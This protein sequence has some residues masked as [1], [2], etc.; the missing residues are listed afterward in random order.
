MTK[1]SDNDDDDGDGDDD[2]VDNVDDGTNST[3]LKLEQQQKIETSKRNRI[4][5]LVYTYI[6][7]WF[8]Y[9]RDLLCLDTSLTVAMLFIMKKER[10]ERKKEPFQKPF[11]K[12]KSEEKIW[13]LRVLIKHHMNDVGQQ[14]PN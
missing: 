5:I 9:A 6:Y 11:D 3:Y 2:H 8:D 12:Y 13:P 1:I 4:N 14:K 10:R 7:T